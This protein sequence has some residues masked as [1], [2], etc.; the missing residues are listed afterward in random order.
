MADEEITTQETYKE[1]PATEE[2]KLKAEKAPAKKAVKKATSS[3]SLIDQIK[4]MNV[5]ELTQLVQAIEKEFGV[6]AIS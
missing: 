5:L 3:D 6:T 2:E 4:N 1:A